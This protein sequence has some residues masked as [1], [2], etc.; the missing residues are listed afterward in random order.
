MQQVVLAVCL[1]APLQPLSVLQLLN[2]SSAALQTE[3]LGRA[4]CV[5]PGHLLRIR[6]VSLTPD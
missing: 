5:N 4:L 2:S 6:S 1:T 3:D